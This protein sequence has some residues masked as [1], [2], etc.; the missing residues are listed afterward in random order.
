M[1]SEVSGLSTALGLSASPPLIRSTESV[2]VTECKDMSTSIATWAALP[3]D[4]LQL[5]CSRRT[6]ALPLHHHD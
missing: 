3:A 4:M 2:V 5:T 1:D 6:H